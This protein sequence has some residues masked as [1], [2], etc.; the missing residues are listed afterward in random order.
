MSKYKSFASQGSFSA[1]QL[2][3]PDESGKIIEAAERRIRGMNTA[4]AFLQKNN[5]LY[6]RAQQYVQG[7][8]QQNREQNFKL[9]TQNRRQY[10]EAVRRNDEIALRNDEI[11]TK[12]TEQLYKDLSSFSQTAFELYGTF[13]TQRKK[14]RQAFA[15]QEVMKSG[16]DYDQIR[17]LTSIDQSLT[18]SAF[19]QTEFIKN[20]IDSGAT[21][22]Q[23]NVLGNMWRRN[24]PNVYLNTQAA[25]QKSYASYVT[26]ADQAIADLGPDATLD[27]KRARL[28]T[29]SSEFVVTKLPGAR[30]EMLEASGL[31]RNMQSYNNQLI[32]G[33]T[34]QEASKRDTE[35]K[36][37]FKDDLVTT[38]NKDG[39][40][41]VI[42]QFQKDPQRWKRDALGEFV[43]TGM[44]AT[45]P[46]SISQTEAEAILNYPI[47]VGGKTVPLGKQFPDLNAIISEGAR[48][49]RRRE[50]GDY[51]FAQDQQ[52]READAELAKIFDEFA[53]DD[54]G[55]IDEEELEVLRERAIS[56]GRPDSP[57]LEFAQNNSV[58]A[59]TDRA[60]EAELMKKANNLTLTVDDVME[61]KMGANLRN[62]MLN[63]ARNQTSTRQ[64][65]IYKSHIKSIEAAISQHPKIKAAPVTGASNY[66][67]I[68]MQD[69][70]VKQYKQNLQRLESPEEALSLT[71]QQIKTLQET[72]G[73][74]STKGTYS[75]IEDEIKS[76]AEEAGKSLD[77]YNRLLSQMTKP[78]FRNDPEFAYNAV[79]HAN[80]HESYN[81]MYAGKEAPPMIKNGAELMGVDP[82][83]FINY[84]ASGIGVDPIQP[85]NT[86][87][88]EIKASLPPIVRRLYDTY[89]TN[90]RTTRANAIVS[91]ASSQMPKRSSFAGND[92]YLKLRRAIIK[93]ESGGDYQIVNPDSG[94][95]GIGQVMPA[96]VGPWTERYL[97]KRLTPEEYRFNNAAQDAVING[98]F[99]DM[100]T[101]Q[102][103]AGYS[104]EV[105]IR[106]A[107]AEWYSGQPDLWNYDKPEYY[108][109]N[110]YPSIAEYTKSIWNSFQQQ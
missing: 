70:F 95:I 108:N 89:R 38:Y 87:L 77:D 63:I 48:A 66:S 78:E 61:V 79:G 91:N 81:A 50:V 67:V 52:E 83:T 65:P 46:G 105:M 24:A 104:G 76:N 12:Q 60:I 96:N 33:Y 45:G 42:K 106:R 2:R 75:E 8:E 82:L 9:E 107:A 4:Q 16:L 47:T 93:Q 39:L 13:E 19:R 80:F 31:L 74:I 56:L 59:F 20:L 5:E 97:G 10:Q 7:V 25:Y 94:A 86:E 109:G 57:V 21:E 58:N 40:E 88:Q 17:Q 53:V 90:E 51:N 49:A 30:A 110:R 98:R 22:D 102:A 55:R 85:K 15:V 29:Y 100:I 54:D 44:K 11:K 34:R 1:N 62:K 18:D 68:L 32:A 72:P 37:R 92:D 43:A 26:G 6:L 23:I 71:L 84:L 69:R 3:A 73:A 41:G 27:Q 101:E 36:N 28:S 14:T 35:V 64:S 103:Q 99:K